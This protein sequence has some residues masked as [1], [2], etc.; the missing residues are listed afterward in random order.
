MWKFTFET[1]PEKRDKPFAV[2]IQ[3]GTQHF[4]VNHWTVLHLKGRPVTLLDTF[5]MSEAGLKSLCES[6]N[7]NISISNF[8][9]VRSFTRS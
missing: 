1:T 3:S 4:I 7:I 5:E 2:S 9:K 6:D 8:T